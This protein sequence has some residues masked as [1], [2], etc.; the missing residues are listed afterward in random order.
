M[1]YGLIGGR[2]G[3]SFSPQ[4]HAWLGDYQYRLYPLAGDQLAAFMRGNSLQGFNVTIPYK[5]QVLPYLGGLS[6]VA[7]RIGAV[8]TVIR[9][10]DGSLYG[11][12]TDYEGFAALLGEGDWRGK[13]AL[14]L[15]SGG[16]ART[17]GAVLRDRGCEPIVV[18]SRQGQDNYHN[19]LWHR[20]ASLMVNTTPVGMYPDVGQA[21][22]SLKGFDQLQLV[23]DLIYNPARTQLML[24]A[25]Q[26]GIPCRGGLKML[27]AQ[28]HK[29]SQLWGLCSFDASVTDALTD[30]LLSQTLNIAL[31]GMP[32]CGK[33]AVGQALAQR[34]GRRFFDT[35]AMVEEKAGMSISQLFAQ[36]GE[37]AFRQLETQ[38]LAE[39]AKQS[40]AIIATGGGIVTRPDNLPL[41]RQNSRILWL[42]RDIQQLPTAGRPLSQAG[43]LEA[44]YAKRAPLYQAW[45]EHRVN[46]HEMVQ[47]VQEIGEAML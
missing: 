46:N 45:A 11:D 9:Q 42:E 1:A 21:P 36:Q 5:Q 23:L 14:I 26:L 16:S 10:P 24:E 44:L 20:D 6:Q 39:A 41:L 8:N 22:L 33:T 18:I 37:A 29:A 4:I 19:I 30:K 34:Y 47:C 32:G 38:C 31:I 27:V 40:A 25:E 35:D 13:K 28:A 7:S 12:N 17:V 2:L 3:H 43:S 15:G